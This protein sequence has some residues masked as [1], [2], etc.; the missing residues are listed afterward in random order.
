MYI[1]KRLRVKSH[2]VIQ[3][4][5]RSNTASVNGKNVTVIWMGI[6]CFV[7]CKICDEQ[8]PMKTCLQYVKYLQEEGL[9]WLGTGTCLSHDVLKNTDLRVKIDCPL[10][11]L[12]TSPYSWHWDWQSSFSSVF[13][14]FLR[15]EVRSSAFTHLSKWNGKMKFICSVVPFFFFFFFLFSQRTV[16]IGCEPI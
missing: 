10:F 12:W 3:Y 8:P 5:Q 15:H 16:L 7:L 9:H 11:R 6:T 14:T 4:L 13:C 2:N 1:N